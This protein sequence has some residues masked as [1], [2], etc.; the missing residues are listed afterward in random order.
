MVWLKRFILSIQFLTRIPIPIQLKIESID[1]V[2]SIIFFPAVGFIIGVLMMVGFYIPHVLLFKWLPPLMAVLIQTLITGAL[3]VD[4]L[5]DTC[6]GIFSNRSKEKML[7]IMRDS[8]IGTNA[9]IA[10]IF[11]LM[12]KMILI[13]EIYS[14][15]G[16][17]VLPV[18][19]AIPI[20][21]RM[22]IIMAASI[23]SYARKESGLGQHFVDG[24]GFFEWFLSSLIGFLLLFILF[25]SSIIT[26]IF[27]V[28][29][30]ALLLALYF[31]AKIGGLT[32]D[33][34][35]AINEVCEIMFLFLYFV[36]LGRI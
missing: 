14:I 31:K 3:H 9:G 27:L 10:I 33:T 28:D 15:I 1:L 35:G 20:L 4:G 30:I 21:G 36:L 34:L 7:E 24:V 26:F 32:G 5:G 19:I 13:F 8:R 12:I 17:Q 16:I 18:I 23:S 29:I 25:R 2:K 11:D 6:D 22:G